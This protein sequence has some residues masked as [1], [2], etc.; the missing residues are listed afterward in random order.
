MDLGRRNVCMGRNKKK[1]T[2]AGNARAVSALVVRAGSGC[3]RSAGVL[4]NTAAVIANTVAAAAAVT[5]ATAPV[6]RSLM[7]ASFLFSR[8]AG[9]EITDACG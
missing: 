8:G 7:T 3:I 5:A 2:S 9:Q 1:K 4:G 6:R